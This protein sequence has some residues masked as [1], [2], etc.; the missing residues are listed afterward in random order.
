V[1]SLN[2]T[3]LPDIEPLRIV[4]SGDQ[5]QG[6]TGVEYSQQLF[7]AGGVGP[8]VWSMGSGSLP[9][10]LTL[11]STSGVIS[12]TPTHPGTFSFT[13]RLTDATPT[14]V[15]SNPIAITVVPG[16]LIILTTGDLTEATKGAIYSFVLQKKGGAPPYTWAIASGELPAG[17]SLNAGTG[18]IS[19]TPTEDGTFNFTVRLTDNQPVEVESEPLTIIVDPEPLVI[20]SSGDLTSGE[21]DVD[22]THQLTFSGGRGPYVWSIMTGALPPGLALNTETG[23]ISG[24]PTATGIFTFRVELTDDQPVT[25]QSQP[26]R[27]AIAP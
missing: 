22:Y 14:T 4:S 25:V 2:L 9:T 19:G 6:S 23:V 10:G 17:L 1:A 8:R 15:T 26:L 5:T 7:F 20:T 21:L 16:P 13:V 3:I 18:V 27:I 24:K 11:G 12:G